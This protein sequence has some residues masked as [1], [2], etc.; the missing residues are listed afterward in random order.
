[1]HDRFSFPS[2]KKKNEVVCSDYPQ[3]NHIVARLY[4]RDN[5]IEFRNVMF[6]S[7]NGN[8]TDVLYMDIT[9]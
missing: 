4:K 8:S 1:M 5:I 2:Q 3:G 7:L 9:F 6:F